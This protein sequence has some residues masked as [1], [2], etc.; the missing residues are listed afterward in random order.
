MSSTLDPLNFKGKLLIKGKIRVLTGLHVGG[1]TTG[2]EIG[3]LDNPVI[4]DTRGIPY[5]PGSTLKGKIRSLLE[6]STFSLTR[7]NFDKGNPHSCDKKDCGICTLFGRSSKDAEAVESPNR[8]I[9]RDAFFDRQYFQEKRSILF[10]DLDTDFTEIKQEN[11][12]DRLTSAAN[13]RP[14]ER[15]PAGTKF[16]FEFIVSILHSNDKMLLDTLK[17]GF[18][19][20]ED[21][22]LGGSGTRGSGKV[23]F[24]DISFVYRTKAFYEE[25]AEEISLKE[26][27]KLANINW[28]EIK[29][30]IS[31]EAN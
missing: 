12:I 7:A 15:V 23:V 22:Y 29:A 1:S 20:L 2:V 31:N 21:D 9:V 11:T 18:T 17:K 28:D 16:N 19:L 10:R 8:L 6:I 27:S 24:E 30:M 14:L 13:P 5:I 4:K 25:K 3:G 26:V